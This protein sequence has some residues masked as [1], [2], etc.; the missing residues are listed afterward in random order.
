[1]DLSTLTIFDY[2]VL[3]TVATSS[4]IGFKRGFST[5]LLTLASWAGAIFITLFGLAS[6]AKDFGRSFVSPEPFA[7][8][9]TSLILFVV[10]LILLKIFA[11]MI[12]NSIKSSFVGPLDRALGTLFG[13]LRGSLVASAVYLIVIYFVSEKNLPDWIHKGQL[14]PLASYGAHMLGSIIPGLP[15]EMD[16][17]GILND[18]KSNLPDPGSIKASLETLTGGYIEENREDLTKAVVEI[19]EEKIKDVKENN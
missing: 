7:D 4:I 6:G 10:S 3:G 11:G 13:L 15:N 19:I 1:M 14:K 9:L 5:E 12:G 8:I 2:L 17:Q 18:M 16:T